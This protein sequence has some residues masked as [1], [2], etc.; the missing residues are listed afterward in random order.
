MPS[1]I[2]PRIPPSIDPIEKTLGKGRGKMTEG[3]WKTLFAVSMTANIT[4]LGFYLTEGIH[5]ITREELREAISSA[6]YPWKTDRAVVMAH[7]QSPGIHETD[8]DK[9][10]RI[11]E[12][13]NQSMEPLAKELEFLREDV[14]ELKTELQRVRDMLDAKM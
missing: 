12:E 4:G 3:L 2:D 6:P 8:T 7:V 5:A 9:R 1:D 14:R 11:R 13:I 10:R